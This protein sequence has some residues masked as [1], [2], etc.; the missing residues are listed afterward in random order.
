[1]VALIHY[2]LDPALVVHY[3]QGGLTAEHHDMERALSEVKEMITI[4]DY[5]ALERIYRT[6]CPH[7]FK[8]EISTK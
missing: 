3:V 1:M 8:V 5:L 7:E 6:G 4:E 2:D